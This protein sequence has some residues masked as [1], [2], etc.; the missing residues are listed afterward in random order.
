MW[1]ALMVASIFQG[2]F[3]GNPK[4]AHP[5]VVSV[6]MLG[7]PVS[8]RADIQ[9]LRPVTGPD[10]DWRKPYRENKPASQTEPPA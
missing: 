7:V 10:S 1:V 5:G 3:F 4:N 9:G 2:N 6:N 8:V